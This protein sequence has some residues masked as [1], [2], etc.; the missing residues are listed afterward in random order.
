MKFTNFFLCIIF[1]FSA[2]A[3]T[4]KTTSL[5]TNSTAS[6]ALI[7]FPNEVNS[8]NKFSDIKELTLPESG[9]NYDIAF[10]AVNDYPFKNI[11]LNKNKNS[12]VSR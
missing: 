7:P 12:N 11:N 9:E 2:C 3:E 4:N 6:N 8:S 1:L 5:T 10:N